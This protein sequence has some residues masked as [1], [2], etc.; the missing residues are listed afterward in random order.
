MC[1]KYHGRVR[2]I[3]RVI[4]YGVLVTRQSPLPGPFG[5]TELYPTCLTFNFPTYSFRVSSTSHILSKSKHHRKQLGNPFSDNR[6][7]TFSWSFLKALH[8]TTGRGQMLQIRP[9]WAAGLWGECCPSISGFFQVSLSV[10]PFI[11]VLVLILRG[12]RCV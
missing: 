3:R 11:C 5:Y 2:C 6:A 8:Q 7:T 12:N 9:R 1:P 10:D 4:F